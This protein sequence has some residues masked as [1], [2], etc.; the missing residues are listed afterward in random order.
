MP[1]VEAGEERVVDVLLAE[2]NAL[3][4]EIVTHVTIQGAVVGLGLTAIG[5]IAGLAAK[6]GGGYAI[7]LVIPPLSLFISLIYSAE[8]Y[9]SAALEIYLY[10]ELWPALEDRVGALPPSWE[11]SAGSDRR[12]SWGAAAEVLLIDL[13][14]TAIFAA[15]S[16]AALLVTNDKDGFFWIGWG[17]TG[18]IL[19]S[20]VGVGWWIKSQSSAAIAGLRRRRESGAPR[21][22]GPDSAR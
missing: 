20:L 16:V 13:P 1:T 10:G 7:L 8:T 21:P 18:L 14:A 6:E 5:V 11:L 3:R 12:F 4:A 17:S 22:I 19:L 2:Y 15:A 9:R